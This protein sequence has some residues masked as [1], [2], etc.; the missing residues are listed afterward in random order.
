M[1]LLLLAVRRK[2]GRRKVNFC[3]DSNLV[4]SLVL[5]ESSW[6]VL[7]FADYWLELGF[8]GSPI[9]PSPWRLVR[10]RGSRS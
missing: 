6:T 7:G 8:G 2:E 5:L 1:E 4:E 9:K 10:V 3:A